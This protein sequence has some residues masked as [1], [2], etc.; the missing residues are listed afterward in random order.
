MTVIQMHLNDVEWSNDVSYVGTAYCAVCGGEIGNL[1]LD[2]VEY[3]L[4]VHKGDVIC[5]ECED[6]LYSKFHQLTRSERSALKRLYPSVIR[7][8]D[9]PV[10]SVN[11]WYDRIKIH[12]QPQ[13]VFQLVPGYGWCKWRVIDNWMVLTNVGMSASRVRA[14]RDAASLLPAICPRVDALEERLV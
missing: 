7:D 12:N 11:T 6:V 13:L 3:L 8:E 4:K 2:E 1:T 9:F 14:E 10:H 5:F